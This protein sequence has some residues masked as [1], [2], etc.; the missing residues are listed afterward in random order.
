MCRRA[1]V[2]VPQWLIG[3]AAILSI[4]GVLTG[5]QDM[6]RW[7]VTLLFCIAAVLWIA[8][9]LALIPWN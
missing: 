1:A 6:R 7:M 4:I 5:P 8:V 3:L 2:N 9:G